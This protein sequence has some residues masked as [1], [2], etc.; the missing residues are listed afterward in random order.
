MHIRGDWILIGVFLI[1]ALKKEVLV[2]IDPDAHS[3]NAFDHVKYGVLAAQKAGVTASQNLSS[4]SL[5]MFEAFLKEQH[6]KRTR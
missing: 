3:V 2:S 6:A 5:S 4:Y 1:I